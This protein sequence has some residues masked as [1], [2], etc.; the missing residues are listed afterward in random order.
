MILQCPKCGNID[1]GEFRCVHCGEIVYP[2]QKVEMK[3]C[4]NCGVK[5]CEEAYEKD[6]DPCERW[7][8]YPTRAELLAVV[9]ELSKVSLIVCEHRFVGMVTEAKRLTERKV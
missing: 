8:H 7:Q 2:I 3:H 5:G 9:E 6:F 1:E 4:S